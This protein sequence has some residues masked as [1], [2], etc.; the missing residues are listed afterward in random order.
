M[1]NSKTDVL[2]PEIKTTAISINTDLVV[3]PGGM[4]AG[5]RC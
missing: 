2:T 4:T 3:L 1:A 5:V